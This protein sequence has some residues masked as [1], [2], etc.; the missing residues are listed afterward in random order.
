MVTDKSGCT[1][2]NVAVMIDV[3]DFHNLRL[4]CGIFSS[5]HSY[6]STA[7]STV[8]VVALFIPCVPKVLPPPFYFLY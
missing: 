6:C 4:L 2:E 5:S 1:A 8:S 3:P 7:Y